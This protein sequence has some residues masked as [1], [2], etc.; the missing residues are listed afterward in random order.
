[1]NINVC[2][3]ENITLEQGEQIS[4]KYVRHGCL[5]VLCRYIKGIDEKIEK[6]NKIKQSM[7]TGIE[8]LKFQGFDEKE[9]NE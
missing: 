3:R 1:M 4:N 7:L 8:I 6:L 5:D 9:S 2:I